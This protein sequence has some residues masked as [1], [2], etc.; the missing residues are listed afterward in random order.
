LDI[1]PS[2]LIGDIKE[3][4]KEAILNGKI[5]N[6]HDSAFEFMINNKD[7]FLKLKK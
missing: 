5:P 1:E 3:A 2:K 4:I 7:E 6:D